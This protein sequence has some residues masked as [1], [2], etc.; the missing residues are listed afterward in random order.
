MAAILCKPISACIEF[1]CTA[2]CKLC[3]G[4]CKLC[5]DG[6]SG[7]CTNPLS[8]FVFM[9]WLTQMPL[10]IAAAVEIPGLFN[11]T[12]KGS[13][14]L[15]GM[16]GTAIAHMFTSVYLANRVVNKTDEKL[17]DKHTAWERI[18][19]LLCHDPWVAIYLLIVIF[20]AAWLIIGSG[21][22]LN[23]AFDDCDTGGNVSIVMGLGWSYLIL[24]PS[25]L[26]C[27]LCC[28]CC[29]KGDY[30]GDDA[31]FAAEQEARKSQR[32]SASRKK[33]S[34]TNNYTS[35]EAYTAADIETPPE[36]KPPRTYSAEGVPIHDD[37]NSPVMEAE[38]VIEEATIPPPIPPPKHDGGFN[39]QQAKVKAEEAASKAAA[40]A[41]ATANKAVKSAKGWFKKKTKGS[42]APERKATLY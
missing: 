11:G 37:G 20:D 10:A 16:L 27:N 2:P 38:V 3:A 42:E 8:A 14:W 41:Q 1:V 39:A 34:N 5:S 4:G 36:P 25:V 26:S 35:G 7:L 30:A 21:W 9:T 15:V 28:A 13:Q 6:L 23:G 19:Y 29:D 17:R 33:S 22:S 18:S 40:T 31:D 24:G 32:Q 12:C